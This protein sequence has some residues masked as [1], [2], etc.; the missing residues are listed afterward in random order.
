[1]INNILQLFQ[2]DKDLY[3]KI[4]GIFN[5]ALLADILSK[6]QI[7]NAMGIIFY[8]IYKQPYLDTQLNEDHNSARN[9]C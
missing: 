9:G 4:K 2:I 3:H 7:N 6:V 1:M 5:N 8:E